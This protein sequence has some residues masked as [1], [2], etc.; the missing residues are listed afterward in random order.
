MK[1]TLLKH[2]EQVDVV[3]FFSHLSF[4]PVQSAKDP[5]LNWQYLSCLEFWAHALG[6]IRQSEMLNSLVYPLT[7]VCYLVADD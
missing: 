6:T 5:V 1:P 4:S 3:S 2:S 7:Q